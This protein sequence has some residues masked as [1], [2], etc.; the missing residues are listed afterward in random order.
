[1]EDLGKGG[2]RDVDVRV[3][4]LQ[5]VGVEDAAVEVGDLAEQGVKFGG[6]VGFRLAQPL[7]EQAQEELAVE[8][9]EVVASF[10]KLRMS[11]WGFGGLSFDR[12]RTS[13][14]DF[15]GFRISVK[16]LDHAQ[17]V[18]EVVLVAVQEA[19]LL[20]EIDEHHPVEHQGGVPVPVALGGEPVNELLEGGQFGAETVVETLGDALHV[21]GAPEPAGNVG[22]AQLALFLPG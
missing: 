11:G 7:V 8:L 4:L 16:V 2:V 15:G 5:L 1:M 14:W 13:G 21:Q 18:A 22:D 6:P 10:D 20:D 9:L 17:A 3:V 19:L 12:L